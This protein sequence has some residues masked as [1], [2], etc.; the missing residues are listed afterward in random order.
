MGATKPP[1]GYLSCDGL[2]YKISE[3]SKLAEQI[4]E[5]FGTYDYYGGMGQQ[6][7]LYPI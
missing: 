6:L 5:G 7:L 3:Y 1:E 4:K 2:T